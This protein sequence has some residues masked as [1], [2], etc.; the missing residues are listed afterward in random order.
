MLMADDNRFPATAIFYPNFYPRKQRN[1]AEM[2]YLL[3]TGTNWSLEPEYA[4]SF[5]S[6]SSGSIPLAMQDSLPRRP[7]LVLVV[8]LNRRQL[9]EVD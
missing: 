5:P 3:V 4:S 1:G 8:L 7:R 9:D 6:W 2:A